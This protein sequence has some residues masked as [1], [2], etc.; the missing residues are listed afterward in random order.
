M[1][2]FEPTDEWA[3]NNYGIGLAEFYNRYPEYRQY[4]QQMSGGGGDQSYQAILDA[5][6]K[7]NEQ[8]VGKIKEFD[9]KNPFV[10]DTILQEEIGKA[11]QRLDPYYKQ[12]LDDY[13]LSTNRKRTR[14]TEDERRILSEINQ[15]V[16]DYTKENKLAVTDA[17][18]KSRE[19]YADVGLY[20]SGARQ[21]AEGRIGIEGQN[22]LKDY[23]QGQERRA[24][25]VRLSTS[26]DLEDLSESER[27]FQRD[28]GSYD[29]VTGAFKR[30]ARS[31][32]ETRLQAIPEVERRRSQREFEMRQYAGVP[33]GV[34][35]AQYYLQTYN[36]LR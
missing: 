27:L 23:T 21:T 26:R 29:P 34:D 4:A 18:D 13:L 6:N 17:L 9:E 12:T 32:A 24:D 1:Q 11:G 28:V 36:L 35:N 2:P 31:E 20:S 16:D 22:R 10:Y 33:A 3:R 15:D 7:Q 25:D 8:F 19:G 14:S 30:G 5:V